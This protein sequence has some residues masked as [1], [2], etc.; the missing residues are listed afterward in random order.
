MIRKHFILTL[1][2]GM[3]E[4]FQEEVISKLRFK[5]VV[6]VNQVIR[7]RRLFRHKNKANS[8]GKCLS[9][10]T[11]SNLTKRNLIRVSVAY[12]MTG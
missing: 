9:E 4:A 11:Q 7:E 5:G 1:S 12:K 10:S 8:A 3:W 2:L 6:Y